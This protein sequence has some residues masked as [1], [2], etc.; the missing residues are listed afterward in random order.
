MS[1]KKIISII[2]RFYPETEAIYLF[3]TYGTADEQKESDVDIALLLPP[4]EAKSAGGLAM[5]D[6]RLALEEALKRTVDL[7]NLRAVNTVFQH[8]IIQEGR[9]IYDAAE[10]AIDVFEMLVMSLYQKLNEER[11]EILKDI[12]RE[13]RT[14]A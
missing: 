2:L 12:F 7:I 3:G 4:R 9:V 1:E 8:E 10:N 14:I 5:S 13:G 11:A 6:C